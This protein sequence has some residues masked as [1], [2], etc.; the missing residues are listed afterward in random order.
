VFTWFINSLTFNNC[1]FCLH[2]IY[3]FRIYLRTNS[4]LCRMADRRSYSIEGALGVAK[5]VGCMGD[6]TRDKP[7]PKWWL[8]S[9]NGL[10][11]LHHEERH[12]WIGKNE[13]SLLEVLKI[14]CGVGERQLLEKWSDV[15]HRGHGGAPVCVSSI[16]VHIRINLTWNQGVRKWFTSNY[17]SVLV[18]VRWLLAHSVH[19]H[20]RYKNSQSFVS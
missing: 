15:C 14:G 12:Y 20:E 11:R 18:G 4:D 2:C 8:R 10:I 16:K 3:V 6:S 5:C 19:I 7:C 1:T 17:G 9:G 13:R